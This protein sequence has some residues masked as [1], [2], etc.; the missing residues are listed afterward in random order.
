MQGKN[1]HGFYDLML[2]LVNEGFLKGVISAQ[3]HWVT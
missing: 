3:A 2:H 1:I